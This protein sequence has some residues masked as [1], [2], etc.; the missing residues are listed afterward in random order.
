MRHI[1]VHE[2]DSYA[3][4]IV[5]IL[6]RLKACIC[7]KERLQFVSDLFHLPTQFAILNGPMFGIVNG[8][9]VLIEHHVPRL[10]RRGR[11]LSN[12]LQANRS[13]EVLQKRVWPET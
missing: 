2:R 8:C 5:Q 6:N 9:S 4:R 3:V 7:R 11:K 10:L 13:R 1:T 12:K